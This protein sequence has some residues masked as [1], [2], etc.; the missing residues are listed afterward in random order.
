MDLGSVRRGGLSP[1]AV[2][3][4]GSGSPLAIGEV[5]KHE[6]ETAGPS[7]AAATA[8]PNGGQ[9]AGSSSAAEAMETTDAEELENVTKKRKTGAGGRGVA[10]L[11]PE[12]LAK[13]RANDREAQRAIRERTKNQIER[14]ERRIQELE[15]QKPYQDLQ[16][17]VRAKEAIEAEN[18]EIKRRLASIIGMLQPLVGP[19]VPGIAPTLPFTAAAPISV[20]TTSSIAYHHAASASSASPTGIMVE[21]VRQAAPPP[22]QSW[23]SASSNTPPA[24]R[25]AGVAEAIDEGTQALL[26]R[27]SQSLR[28]G[29]DFEQGR[30]DLNVVIDHTQA[31]PKLQRGLN[32]A[33]DSG[34][35]HHVPMKHD[36]TQVNREYAP[37]ARLTAWSSPIQIPAAVS[38]STPA[39][40]PPL[41]I[42]RQSTMTSQSGTAS[43]PG[44]DSSAPISI[45]AVPYP[46]AGRAAVL[47]P[48]PLEYARPLR[49][50]SP[51]CPLDALL[52]DFRSE[53]HQRAA[54]GFQPHEVAGPRYPSV[55]SLLNPENSKYSHPV[56]KFFTDI[57]TKFPEV[58]SLPEKVAI[59]YLMFLV[60]RWQISPTKENLERLPEWIQPLPCQFEVPHA[61]WMDFL[62]YP[63][64][65]E[66]V[67]KA[68]NP[69]V[70]YF[71]NFF[72]PFTSTLTLSWPYEEAH[73][74]LRNPDSDE[75][76]INPVFES[77]MRNL[78]NWKLGR[79]FADSFPMLADTAF[80]RTDGVGLETTA[81]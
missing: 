51:T 27:Q 61:A 16:V 81:K 70:F 6:A 65:R 66:R 42:T 23:Q 48:P 69:D 45:P 71:D 67:I 38:D 19:N 37:Q 30:F 34:E 53:R 60:M 40:V 35:Y 22:L 20:G 80:Y 57:L 29:L 52:L 18:V 76:M 64:M 63:E 4:A 28:H 2:D 26:E 47:E 25:P 72:L 78:N 1:G 12:Q 54:E 3:S 36:W 15:A 14:L 21:P 13:K 46:N 7:L 8:M 73:T 62:P 5:I 49:N 11:T 33:Q 74:L 56:S 68:K 9:P 10:N 43:G 75:I 77:H 24:P 41:G 50:C 58:S 59:L 44:S 31:I 55:S 39:T 17:V 79:I 32:G